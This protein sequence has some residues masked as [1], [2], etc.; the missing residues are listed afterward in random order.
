MSH[1][2]LWHGGAMQGGPAA[3]L[4]IASTYWSAA[5]HDFQHGGVNNDFLIKTAHPLAITYNDQSPLEN[6]HLAAAT[7]ENLQPEHLYTP[8]HACGLTPPQFWIL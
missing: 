1:M 5:V 6:H 2:I 3:A 7:V 8:V 4:Q